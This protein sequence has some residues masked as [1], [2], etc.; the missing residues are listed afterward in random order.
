MA[1]EL[2]P[3]TPIPAPFVKAFTPTR[4]GL[5]LLIEARDTLPAELGKGKLY[6][7]L[8]GHVCTLGH[9]GRVAGIPLPGEPG[10]SA[11]AM[12][13]IQ[14]MYRLEPREVMRI[15]MTNDTTDAPERHARMVAELDALIAA[16]TEAAA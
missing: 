2:A 10:G 4:S 7:P 11:D 8:T 14:E 6:S 13:L 9:M 3:A 1:T 16:R 12:L 5:A 15:W